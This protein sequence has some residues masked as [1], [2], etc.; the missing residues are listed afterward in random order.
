MLFNIQSLIFFLCAFIILLFLNNFNIANS[1][2]SN[3]SVI[4]EIVDEYDKI[5]I[6]FTYDQ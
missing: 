1:H 4:Q 6:R 3:N 2:L 5:K